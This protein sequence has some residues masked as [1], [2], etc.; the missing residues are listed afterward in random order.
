MKETLHSSVDDIHSLH[1]KLGIII[2]I[3]EIFTK[4]ISDRKASIEETNMQ[5][6]KSFQETLVS[7]LDAMQKRIAAMQSDAS[8]WSEDMQQ[9][10]GCMLKEN[11]QARLLGRRW[12]AR[13][14]LY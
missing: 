7:Q 1:D 14:W 10:M 4:W 6:F 8:S 12:M 11:L 3:K 9:S 13:D 2:T 5:S